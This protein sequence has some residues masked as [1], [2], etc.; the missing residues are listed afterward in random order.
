MV[1]PVPKKYHIVQR[2]QKHSMQIIRAINPTSS[3]PKKRRIYLWKLI[4]FDS[5][6]QFQQNK[7]IKLKLNKEIKLKLSNRDYTQFFESNWWDNWHASKSGKMLKQIVFLHFTY[8]PAS[9]QIW[10]A[11]SGKKC[12]FFRFGG[13]INRTIIRSILI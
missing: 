6:N 9:S 1:F 3:D 4:T 13:S 10:K 11:F 8:T 5:K 12:D 2:C 7:Q